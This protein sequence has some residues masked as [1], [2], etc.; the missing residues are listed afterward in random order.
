MLMLSG[1]KEEQMFIN[2]LDPKKVK[3]WDHFEYVLTFIVE[4]RFL[5]IYQA[6]L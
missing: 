2:A 6:Y 4:N 3:S 5:R 1:E